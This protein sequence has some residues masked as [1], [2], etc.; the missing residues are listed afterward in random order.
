VSTG[1]SNC[2]VYVGGPEQATGCQI[3]QSGYFVLYSS[4]FPCV[5]CELCSL[6]FLCQSKCFANATP[7]NFA[8]L[9]KE[10]MHGEKA[11]WTIAVSIILM[12]LIH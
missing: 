11:A 9:E 7:F 8:C 12:L 3:C 1:V 2:V 5:G 6:Q 4:C 10:Y